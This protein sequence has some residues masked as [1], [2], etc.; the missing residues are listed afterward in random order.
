MPYLFARADS[1]NSDPYAPAKNS[2][3]QTARP[4]T[5][6]KITC[7]TTDPPSFAS[8][9]NSPATGPA[10][11]PRAAASLGF[12]RPNSV[13]AKPTATATSSAATAYRTGSGS[14]ARSRANAPS[15]GAWARWQGRIKT[16]SSSEINRQA[17][18]VTGRMPMNLPITPLT[19]ISGANAMIV[20]HTL[21]VTLGITSAVPSTAARM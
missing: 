15:D 6:H 7:P 5:V 10:A 4:A 19:N 13:P 1:A 12:N 14:R 17:M 2:P 18:T 21:V 9:P 3:N 20:V 16:L 8:P 11:G